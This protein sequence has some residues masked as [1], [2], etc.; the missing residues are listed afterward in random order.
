LLLLLLLQNAVWLQEHNNSKGAV[1][2]AASHAVA[3]ALAAEA[4]DCS[5]SCC[6]L[7]VI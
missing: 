3:P 7:D 6:V 5:A 2:L 1:A 4:C